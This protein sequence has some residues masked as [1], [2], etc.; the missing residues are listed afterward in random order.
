METKSN[1]LKLATDAEIAAEWGRRRAAK[2]GGR[3]S[4]LRPCV[5]C[6]LP[7]TAS[8]WRKLCKHCGHRNL[9]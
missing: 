1:A 8:E 5:S 2:G 6:F 9:R 3:P 4:V 7:L